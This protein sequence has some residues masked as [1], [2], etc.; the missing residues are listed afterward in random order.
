MKDSIIQ[1]I[2][3]AATYDIHTFLFTILWF[4]F[5]VVRYAGSAAPHA[6]MQITQERESAMTRLGD[7]DNDDAKVEG[8]VGGV[9]GKK[10]ILAQERYT[11]LCVN[12]ALPAGCTNVQC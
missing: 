11:L 3:C 8:G 5:E 1:S 12:I 9:L 7:A 10:K 6:G 4:W 2:Q